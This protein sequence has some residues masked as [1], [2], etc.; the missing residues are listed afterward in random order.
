M[1]PCRTFKNKSGAFGGKMEKEK[2]KPERRQTGAKLDVELLRKFK[3]LAAERETTL[4]ELIEE[5]MQDFLVK[6]E[7]QKER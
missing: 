7:K 4:G 3:V 6:A 2:Q 5:A 1:L